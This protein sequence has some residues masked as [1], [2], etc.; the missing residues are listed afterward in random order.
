MVDVPEN[1]AKY[2]GPY[3]SIRITVPGKGT[4]GVRKV[5]D[6]VQRVHS[7]TGRL[8]LFLET[9]N[10]E[11]TL[12]PNMY[13]DVDLPVQHDRVLT[14]P[15][16][17]ILNSGLRKHVYVHRGNGWF[18]PWRAQT[19]QLYGNRIKMSSG[20]TNA[21]HVAV[22]ATLLLGSESKLQDVLQRHLISTKADTA[23][24]R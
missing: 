8:Q 6:V 20:I 4:S 17:A 15:A 1:A 11:F 10:E 22:S 3:K 12:V 19:A 16:D 23:V 2:D 21:E 18:E 13:V 9:E 14:V 5:D 7:A 24:R